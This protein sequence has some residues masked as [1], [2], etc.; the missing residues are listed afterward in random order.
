VAKEKVAR[1]L[2]AIFAADMVGYSRLMEADEEGIIARH[3]AHRKELIDPK[4]AEHKG[5]IVKTMGDGLLVEFA[6]VVDA[7]RCAVEIQRAMAKREAE[8]VQDRR[9]QY[10]IGINLGDIVIDG[11]D[12][13]GDGVN[14]AA[15]LEAL[16]EQGGI[17][18]SSSVFEQVKKKVQ[19]RFADLG[20]QKVKNIADPVHAFN[21]VMDAPNNGGD[22]TVSVDA[23]FLRPAVAVLP[24]ENL[25][26]NIDQ[27][28][29][30]DG[31]TEDLITA[32]SLWRSFPVIARNS[33]FAYKGRS[34][35]VRKLGADLGAR[36]V[37][38]GSVRKS[39]NR[40]R[41][42]AQLIDAATGHH[43]LAERY[44]RELEDIFELQDALSER[45]AATVAPE[46]ER[47]EHKR[48][49]NKKPQSLDAWDCVQRGMAQLY[50]F[51]GEGNTR[52][53]A[54]F[55]KAIEIDSEYW[56]AFSG[57]AYSHVRDMQIGV[58]HDRERTAAMAIAAARRA[59]R[60]DRSESF[61]RLVLGVAAQWSRD[62][63]MAVSEL[64]SCVR[65]NP[66]NA[67][68]YGS[69]GHELT[70]VG[71]PEEGLRQ[72]ERCIVLNPQDPRN[73]VY[74]TFIARAYL[75]MRSY[76]EAIAWA[77]K[78]VQWNSQYP[79]AHLMLATCLGHQGH[80]EDARTELETCERIRPRYTMVSDNW[81]PYKRKEDQQHFLD[82]LCRAGWTG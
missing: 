72:L 48:A 71:R 30:A 4:I 38:E 12:I 77:G 45:I 70:L 47:T 8:M 11:E 37:I 54:M 81:H 21:I 51:S 55:E 26:G 73:H 52:A 40:V 7:V 28:Y 61:A 15:R 44:D 42:T 50:E 18:I 60:L 22:K 76:D 46:L 80:L 29:F 5:R 74:F 13:L 57:L 16:A 66:C 36:Y 35:D 24:F 34:L 65:L 2:A 39:G 31:L 78:A 43:I 1:R 19:L 41:V 10:R 69:L 63:D 59:V 56:A 64:Q 3:K 9:I 23:L 20:P 75:G 17:C 53:R 79:L 25:T 82:G 62:H 67:S 6:S 68:G 14:I 32:L 33:T 49:V 58:S 27:E